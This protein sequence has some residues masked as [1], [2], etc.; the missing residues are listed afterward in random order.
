MKVKSEYDRFENLAR[1]VLN[2]PDSEINAKLDAEKH[3][4]RRKKSK[5]LP[6]P[7]LESVGTNYYCTEKRLAN[8]AGY[9]LDHT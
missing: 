6:L 3:A 5:F 7:A 2:V 4:K 1:G 9:R 8:S